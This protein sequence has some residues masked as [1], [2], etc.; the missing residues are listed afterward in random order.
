[1]RQM[2]TYTLKRFSSQR[3]CRSRPMR[4]WSTKIW[5][6][7]GYGQITKTWKDFSKPTFRALALSLSWRVTRET[8]Q[9]WNLLKLEIWHCQLVWYHRQKPQKNNTADKNNLEPK[10][11]NKYKPWAHCS[12]NFGNVSLSKNK[13]TKRFLITCRSPEMHKILIYVTKSPLTNGLTLR[14]ASFLKVR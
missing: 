3:N 1:M 13:P 7:V 6:R 5:E 12:S 9:L 11:T 2:G 4:K 8:T 10:Q 14:L